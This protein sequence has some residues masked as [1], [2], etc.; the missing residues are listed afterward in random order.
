MR[1]R[2]TVNVCT[3]DRFICNRDEKQYSLDE[4]LPLVEQHIVREIDHT[5]PVEEF[6]AWYNSDSEHAFYWAGI[7]YVWDCN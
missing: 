4:V 3:L 7:K 1:T 2:Q 5:F 6:R